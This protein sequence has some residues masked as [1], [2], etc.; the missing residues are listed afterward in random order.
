MLYEVRVTAEF[1][2]WLDE[3]KDEIAQEA[4]AARLERIAMGS[5]GDHKTEGGGIS[6]LRINHGP[7]YRA[8]YTIR[9]RVVVF[10]LVGG[11]KRNQDKD[12][13]RARK[14]AKEI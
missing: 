7:G 5:F 6:A 9:G 2:E 3:L 11:T 8:Y 1:A 10:V 12:I 14:L 4:I 13:A